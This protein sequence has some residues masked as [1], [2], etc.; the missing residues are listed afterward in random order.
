MVSYVNMAEK[1]RWL[2]LTAT[3]SPVVDH[4]KLPRLA[5]IKIFWEEIF[6]HMGPGLSSSLDGEDGHVESCGLGPPL[7]NC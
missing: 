2:G 3:C 1:R 5:C 7:V 6:K 4:L